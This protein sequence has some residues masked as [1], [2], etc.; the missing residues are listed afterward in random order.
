MAKFSKKEIKNWAESLYGKD[1]FEA[2]TA[3]AVICLSDDDAVTPEEAY[4][5]ECLRS[6]FKS[7][8]NELRFFDE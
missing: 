5:Y 4:R 6:K 1:L 2:Y 7:D 8:L 3:A